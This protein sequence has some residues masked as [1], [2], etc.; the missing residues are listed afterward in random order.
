MSATEIHPLC[1]SC[2]CN[3]E[4]P[5]NPQSD[6][7]VTCPRC[8]RSDRF[9]KVV[10]TVGEHIVHLTHQSMAESLTKATRGNSF[11]KMTMDKP[12]HRSFRWL[13]DVRV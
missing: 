3:V 8:G 10:E 11:I 12:R 1:G 6:D 4:A 5:P 9:D 7:K 2:K 13:S